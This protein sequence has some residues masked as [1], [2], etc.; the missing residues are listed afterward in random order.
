M[1]S[2]NFSVFNEEKERGD[3][4]CVCVCVCV[5]VS[6]RACVI[7]WTCEFP[8]R[9]QYTAAAIL[10]LAS[11]YFSSFSSCDAGLFV[12]SSSLQPTLKQT[13][14]SEHPPLWLELKTEYRCGSL[15]GYCWSALVNTSQNWLRLTLQLLSSG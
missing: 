15:S 1:N 3:S 8:R 4:V 6:A 9:Q 2:T 14:G 5:C 10:S 7:N 11:G 13:L 12:S